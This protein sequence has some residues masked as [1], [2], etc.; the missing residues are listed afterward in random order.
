VTTNP[1]RA[2]TSWGPVVISLAAGAV[3]LLGGLAVNACRIGRLLSASG[4]ASGAAPGIIVVNPSIVR[5]SALAGASTMR[6]TNLSVSNG[7]GSWIATIGNPWIHLSPSSGGS[8]A[9]A[10][11]RL[12][13]D[14]QDLEPGLHQGVVTLRE[15]E[16]DGAK[17]T[18]AVS[19][20]IQ[21]PVLDVEP[22]DVSFQVHRSNEV[23]HDTLQIINEGTGPLV[24][25]AKTEHRAGW[26]TL[27]DTAGVAPG[28]IAVRA[29]NTGLSIFGT[30]KE[31]II[32]TAPG[33]KNSPKR[34][35]VTLRRRKHGDG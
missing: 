17:A 35:E 28:F 18:V 21:Q 32:V 3:V 23:F 27:A 12:S 7:V 30:F 19:F 14:P 25:T 8:R 31:T 16:A 34:I 33:A 9:N 13:L 4:D 22:G 20:L 5:D 15:P 2:Q 10:N 6:V 29:N 24:W 1:S 26:L 11:V